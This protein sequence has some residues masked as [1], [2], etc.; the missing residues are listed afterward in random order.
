MQFE[1]RSPSVLASA[2][3]Y[4]SECT[5]VA[6]SGKRVCVEGSAGVSLKLTLMRLSATRALLLRRHGLLTL[7]A[8]RV[9][10]FVS[11]PLASHFGLLMCL[12][13]CQ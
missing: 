8:F 12:P 10:M 3:F 5:E 11:A 2:N 7:I 9:N 4:C 1:M 6:C 13:T